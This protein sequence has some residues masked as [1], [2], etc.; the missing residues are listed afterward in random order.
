M[1]F[2][3]VSDGYERMLNQHVAKLPNL[4]PKALVKRRREFFAGRW[5]AAK[6]TFELS[7]KYLAPE[8]NTDRSP[9]WPLNLVG[10][11]SHS[12][13]QAVALVDEPG[14]CVAIGIDV[15][16]YSGVDLVSELKSLILTQNE[17]VLFPDLLIGHTFDIIFSAKESLY[18]ALY[19]LGQSF[20]D[21]QCAEVL[22]IDFEHSRLKIKLLKS[23]R[24][25]WCAEETFVINFEEVSGELFTWL[26]IEQ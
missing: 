21:H 15:H 4:S 8:I 11:I 16:P 5:C 12:D 10:S 9:A 17:L 13:K 6:A 22:Q 26:Y 2:V 1:H 7:G 19:P 23:L 24:Y 14:R 3:K 20:F 25:H 18:K